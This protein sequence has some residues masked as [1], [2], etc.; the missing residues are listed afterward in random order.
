MKYSTLW[1]KKWSNLVRSLSATKRAGENADDDAR[2]N[3]L[4]VLNRKNCQKNNLYG[5]RHLE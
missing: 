4:F 2:T 3:P 1:M 5:D